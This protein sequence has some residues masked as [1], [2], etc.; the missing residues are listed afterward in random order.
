MSL[1]KQ[2]NDI[3]IR[4]LFQILFIFYLLSSTNCISIHSFIYLNLSVF[5]SFS[6]P[7]EIVPYE[8]THNNRQKK[9][10]SLKGNWSRLVST[11]SRVR[12]S[13]EIS[14]SQQLTARKSTPLQHSKV[15]RSP[16]GSVNCF[17]RREAADGGGSE[18]P[19][20]PPTSLSDVQIVFPFAL[21]SF[22][23]PHGLL[24]NDYS[25][26]GDNRGSSTRFLR[27]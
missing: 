20:A 13:L 3:I 6:L 15:I 18:D 10:L 17:S 21:F 26:R 11:N 19:D 4:V 14:L 9:I 16:Q 7:N 27:R 23:P 2:K 24:V 12:K 22:R 8:S 5:K 25:S 1:L